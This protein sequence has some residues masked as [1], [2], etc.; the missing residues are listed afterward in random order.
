MEKV[1]RFQYGLSAQDYIDFNEHYYL[2]IPEGKRQLQKYRLAFPLTALVFLLLTAVR[3]RDITLIITQAVLF[4]I[5][6]LVWWFGIQPVMLGI[7]KRRLKNPKDPA[8]SL[9][10]KTGETTFDF[11]NGLITSVDEKEE[12]KVRFDSVTAVYE[13]KNAYY[14]YYTK[15]K[16]FVLPYRLFESSEKMVEFYQLLHSTFPMADKK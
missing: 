4:F 3:D 12:L 8:N 9:V 5:F 1:W 2:K 11:E 10:D 7:Y 15:A 6:A 16:A 14:F 13:G